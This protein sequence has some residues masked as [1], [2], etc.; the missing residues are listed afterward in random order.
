VS[1]GSIPLLFLD[2]RQ[3]SDDVFV[4][5]AHQTSSF[6]IA[7]PDLASQALI[8]SPD[9]ASQALIASPDLASQALIDSPDL[10]SH[11]RKLTANLLAELQELRFEAIHSFG[12]RFE[13]FH[14]TL[15]PIY[16]TGKSLL[17]H[18]RHLD[19]GNCSPTL[20]P[21]TSVL[22]QRCAI[23]RIAISTDDATIVGAPRATS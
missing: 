12:Q 17:R 2:K 16:P 6:F 21:A 8:A 13:V 14:A 19:C 11:R 23:S 20:V 22:C 18:R 1:G 10:S 15:Q 9:F 7:S 4:E 3:A 5:H